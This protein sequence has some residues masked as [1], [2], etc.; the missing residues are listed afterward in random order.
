MSDTL[1]RRLQ[2]GDVVAHYQVALP[3]MVYYLRRHIDQYFDAQPFVDAMSSNRRVYAVLSQEDYDALRN[4][5]GSRT[6]VIERHP[7]FDAKLRNMLARESP[8]ELLLISN[9]C[10]P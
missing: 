9:E 2:A 1:T 3:S 8:P 5:L 10:R 4:R 6:C 7:T